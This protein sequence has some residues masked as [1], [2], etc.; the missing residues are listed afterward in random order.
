MRNILCSAKNLIL[1]PLTLLFILSSVSSAQPE[2]S[3]L[4]L[5]K[6]VTG[7]GQENAINF[8]GNFYRAS[9]SFYDLDGIL[10]A[11]MESPDA[12]IFNIISDDVTVTGYRIKIF[13]KE[14]DGLYKAELTDNKDELKGTLALRGKF[15]SIGFKK[16]RMD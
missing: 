2:T 12:D 10:Y 9:L 3:K 1:A 14:L 5:G 13:F 11:K 4:F 16:V 8:E 15:I 6:W 7:T